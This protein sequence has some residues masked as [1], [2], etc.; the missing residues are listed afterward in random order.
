MRNVSLPL[1]VCAGTGFLLTSSVDAQSPLGTAFTYQGQLTS[2]GVPVN[3]TCDLTFTLWDGEDVGNPVDNTCSG[4]V[5]P[6][7]APPAAPTTSAFRM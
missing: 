7:A 5:P 3:D 1:T 6:G 4:G 2:N